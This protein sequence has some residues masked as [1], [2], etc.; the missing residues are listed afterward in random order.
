MDGQ[1]P[2]RPMEH[3][4]P[5]LPVRPMEHTVPPLPVRPMEPMEH[6]VPLLPVRPMEH[7]VPPLPVRPM[8]HTV[9]P[10]PVAGRVLPLNSITKNPTVFHF[11][12]T[13]FSNGTGPLF[14]RSA[15][16]VRV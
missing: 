11:G 15:I 7:T 12:R 1:Q 9:P 8:E 5:P 6:T 14:R 4:V 10:L 2:E 13:K 16:W 3:T